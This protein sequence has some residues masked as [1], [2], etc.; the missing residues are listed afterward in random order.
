MC[1]QLS[2]NFHSLATDV[3]S[4]GAVFGCLF[5]GRNLCT[6]GTVIKKQVHKKAQT[7]HDRG[8]QMLSRQNINTKYL[9]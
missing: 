6:L 2:H 8:D 4:G 1:S 7:K 5:R 3:Y 9:T